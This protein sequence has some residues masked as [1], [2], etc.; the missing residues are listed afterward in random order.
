MSESGIPQVKVGMA[1]SAAAQVRGV[2]RSF[3]QSQIIYSVSCLS[4]FLGS[5]ALKAVA[6]T[7]WTDIGAGAGLVGLFVPLFRWVFASRPTQ[8]QNSPASI[9]VVDENRSVTALG[10]DA[11]EVVIAL[12]AMIQNRQIL[13][14]PHGRVT[15]SGDQAYTDD[16]KNRISAEIETSLRKH[17][18]LLLAKL[19]EIQR[20]TPIQTLSS[21]AE[22]REVLIATERDR[23]VSGP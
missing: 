21:G 22:P 23:T 11:R 10:I 16:E 14:P 5:I 4:V 15:S 2:I 3:E 1:A 17:D 13:P 9:T 19:D 7:V 8:D 12:K 6:V 20:G 18:E